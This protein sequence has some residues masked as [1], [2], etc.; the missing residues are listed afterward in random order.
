MGLGG[1][2]FEVDVEVILPLACTCRAR[3]ETGHRHTVCLEWHQQVVY[4]SR[5]VGHR[6]DDAGAVFCRGWRGAQGLGQADHGKTGAVVRVVLDRMGH[7]VQA[8]L[9]CGAFAGQTGPG[10]VGGGKAGGLGVAG[11]RAALG[12]RQVFGQPRLALRQRLRVG[13]DHLDAVQGRVLAQQVVAHHQAHLAH[14]MGGGVQEQVERTG[15]DTF[16]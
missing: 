4:G 15:D 10:R 1:V 12:M 6:D 7:D 3:L 11:D 13:H 8:K 14:H 16:G 2:A 5:L 9:G